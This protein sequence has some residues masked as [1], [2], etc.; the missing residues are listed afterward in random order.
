MVKR[1]ISKGAVIKINNNEIKSH[2][3]SLSDNFEMKIK[4]INESKNI[5]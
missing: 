1:Y 3:F 2:P 4:P 5:G